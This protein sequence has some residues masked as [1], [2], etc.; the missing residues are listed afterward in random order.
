MEKIESGM[1]EVTAAVEGNS[2]KVVQLKDVLNRLNAKLLKK[3]MAGSPSEPANKKTRL[4]ENVA[5]SV[6]Q[7][8][9]MFEVYT[10][11]CMSNRRLLPHEVYWD[12]L[13]TKH[14]MLVVLQV[15]VN[16]I[17]QAAWQWKAPTHIGSTVQFGYAHLAA[18][19]A[20]PSLAAKLSI[21]TKIA[22]QRT[23][24]ASQHGH[25]CIVAHRKLTL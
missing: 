24:V 12:D 19:C 8:D 11:Q 2:L 7:L 3:Q 25:T 4:T 1:Q 20:H 13:A 23:H 22:C 21:Y 5:A 17:T 10:T 15:A 6:A 14:C 16:I 18:Q 9:G